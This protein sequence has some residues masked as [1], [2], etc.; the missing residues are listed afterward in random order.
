MYPK[1]LNRVNSKG[2]RRLDKHLDII[3]FKPLESI[4]RGMFRV[5]ILLEYPVLLWHISKRAYLL[6]SLEV[7][8]F[9]LDALQVDLKSISRRNLHYLICT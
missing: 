4:F 2:L 9:P 3:V 1:V 7:F 8:F 6:K 5:I